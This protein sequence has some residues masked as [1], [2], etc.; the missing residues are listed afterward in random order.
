LAFRRMRAIYEPNP[1]V[2]YYRADVVPRKFLLCKHGE[3]DWFWLP[4]W[5]VE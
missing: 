2:D 1:L 3:T 5:P 4:L